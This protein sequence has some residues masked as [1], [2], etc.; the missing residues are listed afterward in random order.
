MATPD[1]E[2]ILQGNSQPRI[3][4]SEEKEIL[5]E[6]DKDDLR[7]TIQNYASDDMSSA[8]MV[9]SRIEAGSVWTAWLKGN[10]ERLRNGRESG[11]I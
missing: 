1:G 11:S 5:H 2:Q 10:P 4:F 3:G 7:A 9:Q 8:Q 6:T